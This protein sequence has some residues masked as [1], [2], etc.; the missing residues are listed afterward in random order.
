MTAAA[1]VL[2]PPL[3]QVGRTFVLFGKRKLSYFGG[4][5][6]FRLSSDRRVLKAFRDGLKTFGL[7]VAASR[8]TTGNH[9]LYELLEMRLAEFFD[10]PVALLLSSGYLSNLAV[11]QALVGTVSHAL[12]DERAH[13]SLVDAAA[14]LNCPTLRF[15][16]RDVSDLGKNL[17]RIGRAPR[18]IVLTDGMFSHDGSI[19]PLKDYLGILP[20]NGLILLDDAHAAG[21]LG[22]TGQGTIEHAGV[23]RQ[24]V[25]QTIA[26]SKAFGVYGGA[27]L[28]NHDLRQTVESKSRLFS[29]NTPLPLPIAGGAL[30]ATEILATGKALRTRLLKN[31]ERVKGVLGAIGIKTPDTPC[32]IIAVVPRHSDDVRKLKQCCLANGVSPPYIHYPGGPSGGYFR[33]AVSSEHSPAQIDAFTKALADFRK[34]HG[35]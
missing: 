5:D 8:S 26:L 7:T 9:E 14:F 22:R 25:I 4:C 34:S 35:S 3:R 10:A 15:K 29:G 27:I 24:Q 21:V 17:R 16:H 11:A 12:L 19:A 2:S 32:P 23:S 28:C 33:F 20:R 30:K 13:A 1:R 6:Y 18:P 31:I